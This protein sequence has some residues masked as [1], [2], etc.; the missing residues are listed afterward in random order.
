MHKILRIFFITILLTFLFVPISSYAEGSQTAADSYYSQID[1]ILADHDIGYGTEELSDKS[2]G[3]LSTAVTDSIG[4]DGTDIL[5][6]LGTILIVI[7]VTAALKASGEGLSDSS[8]DIFG[9]VSVLTAVTAIVPKLF[10][11]FGRASSAVQSPGICPTIMPASVWWSGRK[12]SAPA[13]AR[14]TAA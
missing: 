5:S 4:W 6:L 14:P 10:E 7:V 12:T 2:F 13:P 9:T 3:E 1:E 8:A 11:V